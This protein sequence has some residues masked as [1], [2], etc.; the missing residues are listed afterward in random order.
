MKI[1]T[2]STYAIQKKPIDA[3]PYWGSRAWGGQES[4]RQ[5]EI[6]SE[7][8]TPYR[9]RYCYSQSIDTVI[10]KVTTDDGLI[11][12]GEAKAPVAPRVT[13]AII[14]ELLAGIVIGEDP[15]DH[16]V[17]WERMYA[18]MRV[19]GHRAGF[20]LEAI[21]GVDIA[22][23][24]LAGKLAKEPIYQL[25]GGSFRNPVRV[26]ASGLPALPNEAPEEAFHEL[27]G[28]AET[29]RSRGFTGL[30]MALGR[31]LRGDLRSV[32]AVRD[33]LG[34]DFIIYTDA[35][36]VYDRPQ[37][38][39][40][41]RE[42]EE[43]GVGWLEM[44]IFPEDVEG[45]VELAKALDL[46]IA[47][48]SL[49]SRFEAR[50]LIRLGG[51][52]IVQPDVCRAGGITE[53]RRIAELADSFGLAFAPHISIGSAIHFAATAH[54]ASAMPNTLTSEYWIGDNPIGDCILESPLRL[55]NGYL[56]TPVGPGLGI[57]IRENVLFG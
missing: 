20:Y 19:R 25:L 9:R 37:A 18:G 1:S 34:P 45:Y 4:A 40:L 41:G 33:R 55:M 21:S 15:R 49:T 31:G 24:D 12:F 46:P 53:C 50:E 3:K 2:V 51:I 48:D 54:M 7:Y 29:I 22:L 17:L 39:R 43:L 32:R 5:R 36:G 27:A 57:A 11:G 52:D 47:L 26:Y 8:P 28:E 38:L 44:P 35:A 14:D 23:W 13:K 56:E 6:S 16:L 42:L 10:V 30:K